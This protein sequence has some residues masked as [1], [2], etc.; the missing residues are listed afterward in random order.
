MSNSYPPWEIRMIG[1]STNTDD[2][3]K[4][5][6]HCIVFAI[7]VIYTRFCYQGNIHTFLLSR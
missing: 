6:L 3:T 1:L 7:K 2:K 4:V 5:L